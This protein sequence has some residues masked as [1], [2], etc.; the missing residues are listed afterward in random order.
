[1]NHLQTAIAMG[2]GFDDWP[3]LSTSRRVT[4]A[5]DLGCTIGIRVTRVTCV[6]QSK[7][8]MVWWDILDWGVLCTVYGSRRLNV[9]DGV[10][11]NHW[12]ARGIHF[13]PCR[14]RTGQHLLSKKRKLGE[15]VSYPLQHCFLIVSSESIE[16]SC[17]VR[18]LN[19][20]FSFVY[21]T[22][23]VPCVTRYVTINKTVT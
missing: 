18:N 19:I 8:A 22:M 2:S 7:S 3:C 21:G 15:N 20:S 4:W 6:A 12:L 9:D 11:W 17:Y 10:H 13:S 23:N 16:T 5:S 14:L 1:M